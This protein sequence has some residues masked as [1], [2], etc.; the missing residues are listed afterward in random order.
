MLRKLGA[1]VVGLTLSAAV[2]TAAVDKKDFQVI[3]DIQN[4]VNRYTHFTIFDDVSARIDNGVVTL[5][6]AVTMPYKKSDIVKRVAKVDGVVKV[7]DRISVLPTSMF[8]DQ[9]RYRIARAVYRDPSLQ[10][11][12]IGP[13][14]PIHIVVDHGHVTLT[15][16]VNSDFDRTVAGSIVAT[17]FGVMS[18]KNELKTDKEVKEE[19]ERS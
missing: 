3:K 13:N 17:Q 1:L 19:L 4:T 5:S 10:M 9:L 16:I 14:P 12:G 2:A 11:Y 18:L 7:Q 15:G 6:G 8:D